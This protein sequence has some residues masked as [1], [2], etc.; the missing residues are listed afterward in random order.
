MTHEP[1]VIRATWLSLQ[2]C[3]P[4]DWPDEKVEEFANKDRLSGTDG[5]KVR[6]QHEYRNGSCERVACQSR[7]GFV[8]IIL[9]C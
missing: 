9:D 2:V 8:H 1:Q 3:V 7:C 6:K 4:G 5:W